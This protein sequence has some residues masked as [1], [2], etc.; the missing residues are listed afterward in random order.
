MRG[1]GKKNKIMELHQIRYFMAVANTLNFTRAAK[2][3]NVTQPALTKAEQKLEQELGG[4]LI[5]RER[6]LTQLTELGKTV[7]PMLEQA[8]ASVEAVVG[9]R[10]DN[11][12]LSRDV[13]HRGGSRPGCRGREAGRCC[14]RRTRSRLKSEAGRFGT[15]W[16]GFEGRLEEAPAKP[17]R[18]RGM[19]RPA[20]APGSLGNGWPGRLAGRLEH[21]SAWSVWLLSGRLGGHLVWRVNER[22][23]R[24]RGGARGDDRAEPW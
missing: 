11:G 12:Q 1:D 9:D 24:E 7:L 18:A 10:R 13:R 6:Q 16:D 5:H 23:D 20:H 8:L 2:Q 17:G 4:I 19:D 14:R 22:Q 15:S 21:S 3:C